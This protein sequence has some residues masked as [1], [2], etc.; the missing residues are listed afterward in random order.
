[1]TRAMFVLVFLCISSPSKLAFAAFEMG[2][3]VVVIQ[4]TQI[5]VGA[6]VLQQVARGM[7][8]K[9]QAVNGDWL[10]VSNEATGWIAKHVV[11][12]P[13]EA[14]DVFTE[15][16]RKNPHDADAHL[17]RGLAWF[18]K[19]E[20]DIAISDFNEA[21]RLDPGHPSAYGSRAIC[22]WAKREVDKAISDCNEAIRIDSK[23]AMHYANRGILWNMKG[24]YDK[25]ISDADTA[26]RMAPDFFT[27]RIVRGNALIRKGDYRH[28]LAE[29]NDALRINPR[30]ATAYGLRGRALSSAGEYDRA[31]ADFEKA[32][33]L[34]PSDK[35]AC[36]ELAR[37]YA[38]CP[39]PEYRNGPKALEYAERAC[40]L[41]G[42]RWAS[43][44]SVLAAAYAEAGDFDKAVEWQEKATEMVP[45][46]RKPD[47]R[48]RL[49]L[50][51]S[52]RPF[53]ETPQNVSR[54]RA[55]DGPNKVGG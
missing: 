12:T 11:A 31:A 5:K 1:M 8:L 41:S 23:E 54:T 7:G 27:P 38:T 52:H 9:V 25:A 42:W 45:I 21:I 3:T 39:M 17:C 6:K 30:D 20:V 46:E 22:W 35:N 2:D 50:Y 26:I 4:D 16:I 37:F 24:N 36:N 19:N 13:N 43:A 10:W 28:A 15:E 51:K 14:I 49:D 33:A 29:F 55:V 34:D 47:Y 53:R 48:A 18:D 40:Q 44:I 32:V